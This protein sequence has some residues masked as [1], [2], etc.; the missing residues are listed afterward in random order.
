MR[1][2]AAFLFLV[3]TAAVAAEVPKL[4]TGPALVVDGDG[5]R[6]GEWEIRL[7]G[8]DAPEL[9]DGTKRLT[10]STG[11]DSPRFTTGRDLRFD[12]FQKQLR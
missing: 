2:P 5:L 6:I 8:I 10:C 11:N 4:V 7:L 1:L 9:R 3:T 12:L